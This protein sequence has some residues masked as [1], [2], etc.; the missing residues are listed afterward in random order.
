MC[1]RFVLTA[2]PE[3]LRELFGVEVVPEVTARYNIAPTQDVAVVRAKGGEDGRELAMLHWGL[4]PSWAKDSKMASRTINARSETVAEKPSFRSAF[5]SRRCLIPADGFY[6][7]AQVD[8]Y[9]QPFYIHMEDKQ[10]FALAGLWER[11]QPQDGPNI[12]SCT[13]IT[14]EANDLVAI[15]HP[16]MPVVLPP[17]THDLW[18]DPK[19][20]EPARL[21]A[22]LRPYPSEEMVIYPVSTLVSNARNEGSQ[23]IESIGRS[24][25]GP[26]RKQ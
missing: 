17:E 18:L 13:I 9:K 24:L 11:W 10:P 5:R 15:V 22:L 20:Q 4:I 14:T 6:E 2:S 3:M 7:W 25:H 1:G 8:D 12:E 16:R 26:Q 21:R 23:C 19:M